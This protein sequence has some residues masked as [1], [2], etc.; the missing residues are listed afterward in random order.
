MLGSGRWRFAIRYF[1]A[2]AQ[3]YDSEAP[4]PTT[5]LAAEQR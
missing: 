5:A 2:G 4:A 1:A 3:L